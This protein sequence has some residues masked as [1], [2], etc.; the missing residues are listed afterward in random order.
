KASARRRSGPI[1][2]GS[3]GD[4]YKAGVDQGGIVIARQSLPNGR[5][6]L[7][8]PVSSLCEQL[9]LP[10]STPTR[11]T[12]TAGTALWPFFQLPLRTISGISKPPI[13]ESI[14]LVQIRFCILQLQMTN[15]L[16]TSDGLHQPRLPSM[17]SQTRAKI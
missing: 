1:E 15:T 11:R 17:I 13:R 9:L 3:C 4:D 14:K 10:T 5:L 8:I 16:E 6:S 12:A 2:K 7:K